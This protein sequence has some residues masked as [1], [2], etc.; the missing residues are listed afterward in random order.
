MQG[1]REFKVHDRVS[2]YSAGYGVPRIGTVTRLTK[3]QA[4]VQF[5]GLKGEYRYRREDGYEV[6][7]GKKIWGATSIRHATD[8]DHQDIAW[9]NLKS[10]AGRL[11]KIAEEHGRKDAALQLQIMADKLIAH[12][13]ETEDQK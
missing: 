6:G 1:W 5:P 12:I 4:I 11:D 10:L 13:N 2:T 8:K 3:T 9:Q 7:A